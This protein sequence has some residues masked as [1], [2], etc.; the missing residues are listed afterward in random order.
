MYSTGVD[1]AKILTVL[2]VWSAEFDVIQC[3]QSKDGDCVSD[4]ENWSIAPLSSLNL[5]VDTCLKILKIKNKNAEAI[6]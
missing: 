4:M 6:V 5:F 3:G 1:T 2:S